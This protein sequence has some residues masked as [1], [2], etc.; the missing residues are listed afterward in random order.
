MK[1]RDARNATTATRQLLASQLVQDLRDLRAGLHA[2]PEER[3]RLTLLRELA[4]AAERGARPVFEDREGSAVG[5]SLSPGRSE[6][7][8]TLDQD[9][10]LFMLVRTLQGERNLD[11]TDFAEQVK[12]LVDVLLTGGWQ[13]VEPGLQVFAQGELEAFLQRMERLDELYEPGA[14]TAHRALVD[15]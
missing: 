4:E 11:V 8:A 12:S 3:H 15:H 10:E 7:L 6:R 1:D 2:E 5:G 9:E 13:T 14:Q